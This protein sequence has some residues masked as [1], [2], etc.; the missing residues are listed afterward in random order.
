VNEFLIKVAGFKL[1]DL[2]K[3]TICFL[4]QFRQDQMG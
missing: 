4:M 3:H 1:H 2:P